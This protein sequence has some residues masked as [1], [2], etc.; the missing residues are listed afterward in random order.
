[1]SLYVLSLK[2]HV[3]N[4]SNLRKVLVTEVRHIAL[5]KIHVTLKM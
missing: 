3:Y 2:W 1:M 5:V 4:E